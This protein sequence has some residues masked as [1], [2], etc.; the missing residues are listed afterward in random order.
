MT[1]NRTGQ[2]AE[3]NSSRG[4][5]QAEIGVKPET[6]KGERGTGL[7]F[8]RGQ[9][10]LGKM[11]GKRGKVSAGKERRTQR[12][13]SPHVK[14]GTFICGRWEDAEGFVSQEEMRQV[15]SG[16]NLLSVAHRR[17]WKG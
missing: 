9:E 2:R 15:R 4:G 6:F 8:P 7:L 1:G 5:I 17:D 13:S 3:L 12:Q 10:Q 16:E 14:A 11:F